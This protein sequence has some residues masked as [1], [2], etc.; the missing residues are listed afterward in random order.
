MGSLFVPATWHRL[1]VPWISTSRR[2]RVQAGR[3]ELN[4]KLYKLS[5][6]IWPSGLEKLASEASIEG[7]PVVPLQRVYFQASIAMAGG[8]AM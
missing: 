7:K 1:L 2:A 8:G 5:Y 6:Y 3:V 4:S